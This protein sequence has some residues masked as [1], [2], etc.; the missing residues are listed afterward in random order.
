VSGPEHAAYAK[1]AMA[2]DQL[3]VMK[4]LGFE[5]FHLVGHD[6]GARVGYRLAYDAPDILL[7]LSILDVVATA[8]IFANV[9]APLASAYFHWFLMLQPEPLAETLIGADPAFYLR[10]LLDKWCTTPGAMTDDAFAEYLRCF[11]DPA[12]L[13]AM[14]EDY[15][16]A[17][18][19][20]ACDAADADRQITCP[21]LVLWGGK[22]TQHPGWPSM[23]LDIMATWRARAETVVGNS[24]PC[25]HFL[26][27]EAPL[28]T[29]DA[30]LTFLPSCRNT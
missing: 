9:S 27:E 4:A 29:A 1:R 19:D 12:T 17:P 30:L 10:W 25:G 20:I 15:R 14:C 21:V 3:N 11:S 18:L 24:L 23:S 7:S 2:R 5:R 26:P 28:E 16:S 22:Q 8:D 13:H 6:R